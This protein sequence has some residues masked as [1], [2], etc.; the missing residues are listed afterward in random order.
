MRQS[1]KKNIFLCLI[2]FLILLGFPIKCYAVSYEYHS[3]TKYAPYG[4][5]YLITDT[6]DHPKSS[7]GGISF[8]RYYNG[9]WITSNQSVSATKGP[10]TDSSSGYKEYTFPETTTYSNLALDGA[11]GLDVARSS[12]YQIWKN[13]SSYNTQV[14]IYLYIKNITGTAQVQTTFKQC[15]SEGR[16]N[17]Y[18]DKYTY[19]IY[20]CSSHTYGGYTQTKAPTC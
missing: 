1:I 8:G 9:K 5:T 16:L 14:T 11:A 19:T 2:T 7:V 13:P 15:N 12:I 4:S 6:N 3:I 10:L 17:K 18:F 20:V